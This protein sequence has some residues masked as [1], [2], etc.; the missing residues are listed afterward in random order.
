MRLCVQIVKPW[1]FQP[2]KPPKTNSP[3]PS[4]TVAAKALRRTRRRVWDQQHD[5]A[6][7]KNKRQN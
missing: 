3:S 5:D 6:R 1:L 7:Q 2:Q 4:K